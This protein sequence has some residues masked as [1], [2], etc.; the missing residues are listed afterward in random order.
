MQLSIDKIKKIIQEGEGV[1][2]EFKRSKDSLPIN[3]F[4]TVCS[5]LNRNGGNILLGV[6]DDKVIEGVN[7]ERAEILC[8]NIV[9]QSNNSQ[10]LF[11]TFLLDASIVKYEDKTLIHVLFPYHLKCISAIKRFM[12]ED[13]M[14]IL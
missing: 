7:P 4:E 8:K 11:P 1:T 3:L 6:K 2:V 5:F 12:I 9:N 14:G 13:L 10:K